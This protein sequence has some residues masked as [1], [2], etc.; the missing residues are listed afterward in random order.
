MQYRAVVERNASD[1]Y[2][3]Q[4]LHKKIKYGVLHTVLTAIIALIVVAAV[5]MGIVAAATGAWDM[6]LTVSYAIFAALVALWFFMDRILAFFSA[7][8]QLKTGPLNITFA[9]DEISVVT[10]KLK[11]QYPY[12]SV[13]EAYHYKAAYY[14]Y[15]DKSHAILL[16]ERCFVEGSMDM[17][18]GF[19]SK[20]C[21]LTV[22]EVK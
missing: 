8:M 17:F 11:E 13:I 2:N 14:L 18:G 20:K 9:E 10:D 21:G 19:I 5:L 6:E 15:I 3:Y 4:R 22:K 1:F 12:A 16:P 7:R